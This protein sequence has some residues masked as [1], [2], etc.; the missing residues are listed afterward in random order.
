MGWTNLLRIGDYSMIGPLFVLSAFVLS[1]QEVR[2]YAA[3]SAVLAFVLFACVTRWFTGL[4]LRQAWWAA[5]LVGAAAVAAGTAFL[6]DTYDTGFL[7]GIAS[8]FFLTIATIVLLPTLLLLYR[9]KPNGS[10]ARPGT[11][12]P[13]L[14]DGDRPVAEP[15][16]AP[17]R[18]GKRLPD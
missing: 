8:Q 9:V 12:P 5:A 3:W 16:R 7:S 1:A 11:G 13:T 18:G 17:D 10:L 15:G 2:L 4:R 14:H 6:S